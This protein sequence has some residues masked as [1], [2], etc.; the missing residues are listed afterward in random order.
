MEDVSDT[1]RWV[2]FHR[3]LESERPTPCSSTPSRCS[4]APPHA[5]PTYNSF[6]RIPLTEDVDQV[7]EIRREPA[8]RLVEEPTALRFHRWQLAVKPPA[9]SSAQ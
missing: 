8:I 3:A 7:P 5:N 1:A 9:S 6:S 4:R 2:A